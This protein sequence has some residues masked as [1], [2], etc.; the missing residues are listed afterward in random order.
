MQCTEVQLNSGIGRRCWWIL[1]SEYR[2]HELN[3]A[4][5]SQLFSLNPDRDRK[6]NISG[7]DSGQCTEG[8]PSIVVPV[9]L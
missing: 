1:V 5:S 6:A 2:L 9:L 3:V 4:N 7:A 8:L